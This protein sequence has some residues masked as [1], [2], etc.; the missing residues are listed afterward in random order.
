MVNGL[1]TFRVQVQFKMRIGPESATLR[2]CRRDEGIPDES[3]TLCLCSSNVESF[4]GDLP[5]S[6]GFPYTSGWRH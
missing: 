6:R 5:F 2:L 1:G 4:S 3:A